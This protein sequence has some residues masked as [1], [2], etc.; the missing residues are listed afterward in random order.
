MEETGRVTRSKEQAQSSYNHLARWY[1]F[2]TASEKRY[3]REG[4]AKLDV[5]P[6]ETVLEVGF[7]TGHSLR[8]LA[9]LVGPDGKVFGIDIS[10]GMLRIASAR[11]QKV[12][13]AARVDLQCG[14]AVN[15]PYADKFFDAV[16]ISFTLE[17][18]DTP[19]IPA[20]LNELKRVLKS[21]G[22]LCVVAMSKQGKPNLMVK[23]YEWFHQKLP[24]YVDCR[25]IYA[26]QA[27]DE[28]GFKVVD[29]A[30]MSL[31]NLPVEI[32]LARK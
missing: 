4:L 20:V 19:E 2:F 27:I 7:G 16:F 21:S 24:N 11:L 23:L 31:W 18:F 17:L 22:R 15:L 32:I 25:P 13:L 9:G 1:D 28:A 12:G 8:Q 29:V 5:K 3:Q 30:I 26:R 14:D 6:G 10:D